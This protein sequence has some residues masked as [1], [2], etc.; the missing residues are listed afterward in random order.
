MGPPF[1]YFELVLAVIL[2]KQVLER[3]LRGMLELADEQLKTS[4]GAT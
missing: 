4:S 2:T 1:S 3:I